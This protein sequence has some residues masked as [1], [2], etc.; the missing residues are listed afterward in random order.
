MEKKY[1]INFFNRYYE[2]MEDLEKDKK[3]RPKD[4]IIAD[5]KKDIRESYENYFERIRKARDADRFEVYV[6]SLLHVYDPHTEYFSPK[7]KENFNINM[8]GKLEGIGARLQAEKEYTKVVSI[9]PASC[10]EAER[11][12]NNDIIM[13]VNKPARNSWI[14]RV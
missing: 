7:D 1:P 2:A 3:T 10:M 6:N 9:V 14:S 13:A 11:I 4:S 8:S 12:E 5:I